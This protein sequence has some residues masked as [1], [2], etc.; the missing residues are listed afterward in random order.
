MHAARR[1]QADQ[2][3]RAAAGLEL[4]KQVG[5]RRRAA[6]FAACD[7]IADAREVLHH[8]APGPDIEMADLGISHLAVG[9]PNILAGGMQKSVR[10]RLPKFGESRRLG[11]THSVVR[12][13]LAPAEAIENDQ[14][15]RSSLLH[16]G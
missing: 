1:D 13:L 4:C 9:Q 6:D 10:T 2:M 8:Y 11:L 15:H 3:T 14:H 7:R 16:L 12:N 5:E